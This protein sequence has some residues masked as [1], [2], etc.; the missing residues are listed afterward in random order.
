MSRLDTPLPG[1]I[2][3][4]AAKADLRAT[5]LYLGQTSEVRA[6]KF[7]LAVE[8]TFANWVEMPHLGSPRQFSHPRLHGLRQWPVKD[9]KNYLI[10]YRA[11][12]SGD[13]LEVLRMLHTSRDSA[14]HLEATLEAE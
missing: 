11:F 13:G 9:F 14:A 12:A 8:A 4:P 3:Q 1:L 5:F 6:Q 7:A 2:L 10:F